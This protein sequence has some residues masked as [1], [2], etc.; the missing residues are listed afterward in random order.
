MVE[1][2]SE[3][4]HSEVCPNPTSVFG[5]VE[6]SVLL[7]KFIRRRYDTPVALWPI[8]KVELCA[9]AGIMP[10]LVSNWR[11]PLISRVSASDASEEGS[12]SAV[13]SWPLSE[14]KDVGGAK[15]RFRRTGGHHACQSA[16]SAAGFVR[17][18]VTGAWKA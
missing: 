9:F 8:V 7:Y 3:S 18:D 5:G 17:G 11:R 14:I 16:L 10:F 15:L 12:E 13:S 6:G 4:L 2:C 1:H